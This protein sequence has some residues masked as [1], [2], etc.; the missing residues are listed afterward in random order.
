[1][2]IPECRHIQ[3]TG[4]VQGVGF[5][6]FVY[7][8]ARRLDLQ[9]EVYNR[10]SGVGITVQGPAS[11]LDHFVAELRREA[12]GEPRDFRT[13][14]AA[15]TARDAFVIGRSR[16]DPGIASVLLTDQAI[17]DD[18]R[19]EFHDPDNRRY[20][21]PFISCT[22]CGPRFSIC[23]RLP[24]DRGNTS[25]HHFPLCDTCRQEYVTPDAR[26]F[27]AVGLSCPGCGPVLFTGD[28]RRGEAALN[29]ACAV[30]AQGGVVAVKGTA[31]FHLMADAENSEALTRLR[32]R[33]RR[34]KPLAVLA[35][36]MYWV[37]NHATAEEAEIAALQGP[38]AP[39][40][41]LQAQDDL[42]ELLAP[43]LGMLGVMLPSSGIQLALMQRLQRPLVATSANV[44]GAPLIYRNDE[45]LAELDGV[46]DGF[47]LH[48]LEL[49]QG[50]DD[51]LVRVMAGSP[52]NLR[53]GRG[54]APQIEVMPVAGASLGCGAHLKGSLALQ[55]GKTLVIGPHIGDLGGAGNRQRYRQQ[56]RRLPAFFQVGAGAEITDL[57]PDY[58]STLEADYRASS[59]PHH[60]AHAMAAWIEH[61]PE[62]PFK[63]LAWDG[64]GLGP[65]GTIWGG[66]CLQFEAG[67]QWWRL[68]SIR[69]FRLPPGE[70]VAR[71]PGRVARA[72]TG[73]MPAGKGVACSSMGRLIEGLAALAGLREENLF[74]AQVAMEW[75]ALAHAAGE[76]ATMDFAM[77]GADLDW[78]PLLPVIADHRI[79]ARARSLG[80]HRAL[81]RAAIRQCRRGH[82]DRV[83]LSGGVFQNRLLVELLLAEARGSGLQIMLPGRLPPNDG[84]IAA[85]QCV[86]LAM[87]VK[88]KGATEPCV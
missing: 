71:Y 25:W 9:G 45:A 49:V 75:E 67:L 42:A 21:Y 80:F 33:K 30:L 19:R 82:G 17:C 41:L 62:P 74:E 22:R 16:A 39:I 47:L 34:S 87:G 23:E 7:R 63:V 59:V 69:R 14:P 18:C 27:H 35:P 11:Q 5:R 53:L 88:Q 83:L 2:P 15:T 78:R 70:A 46:A 85:G 3:V 84:G 51:S 6:P 52:V 37:A 48:D 36:D 68:G 61:Q 55:E 54:L 29:A 24:W 81:A 43:G 31:G 12:P 8:L 58:G 66:E 77:E 20:H 57:H 65:D 40:V 72:L 64:I 10:S 56:K 73:E 44:S 50:L 86:A 4:R 32:V 76:G 13:E 79:A 1:M 28:G 60:I 38:A 26:R